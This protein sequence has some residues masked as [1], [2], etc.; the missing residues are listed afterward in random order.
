MA[1]IDTKVIFDPMA[2]SG[3]TIQ[4]AEELRLPWLAFEINPENEE[5][6]KTRIKIGRKPKTNLDDL[7]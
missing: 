3:P 6:I 2:G 4:I 7:K 5:D 1:R